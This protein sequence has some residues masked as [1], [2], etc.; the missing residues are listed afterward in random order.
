LGGG[1]AQVVGVAAPGFELLFPPGTNV[2]RLPN[3]WIAQRINFETASRN[4]VFLRVIA[5]LKKDATLQQAQGQVET[6]AADLR[7]RF[8]IKQTAGLHFRVEPMRED[9]VADVRP[10][11]LALMGAVMF[12][13]WIACAD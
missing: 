4:N 8:P 2:D 9:L 12:V 6:V 13:L 3:I 1:R 10:A 5:R 11:I 7:K